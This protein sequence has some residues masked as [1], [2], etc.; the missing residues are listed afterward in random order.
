[1][2][3]MRCSLVS[4]SVMILQW[5]DLESCFL[6]LDL[7]I[8]LGL[9]LSLVFKKRNSR[10]PSPI[11]G[12][13]IWVTTKAEPNELLW[14]TSLKLIWKLFP[15]LIVFKLAVSSLMKRRNGLFFFLMAVLP[16]PM[17]M[18]MCM[19]GT[20]L[21]VFKTSFELVES[22]VFYFQGD[23]TSFADMK[24]VWLS[25][26]FSYVYEAL[27]S[28]NLVFFHSVITFPCHC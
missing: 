6:C 18:F 15:V 19:S 11:S 7:V 22:L 24:R 26:K 28:S 27:P 17:L 21:S 25:R 23:L 2:D 20:K 12:M 14:S 10:L 16:I 13:G 9:L 4:L 5:R 1:M 3:M 8:I